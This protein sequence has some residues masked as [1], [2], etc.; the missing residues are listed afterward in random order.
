MPLPAGA[1]LV[2]YYLDESKGWESAVA[3][4]EQAVHEAR[5]QGK[6]LKALVVINPVSGGGG[7]WGLGSSG[8]TGW[9]AGCPPCTNP[10]ICSRGV[11]SA[12]AFPFAWCA[13]GVRPYCIGAA[14][15]V[16]HLRLPE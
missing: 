10:G 13:S 7:C 1:T 12:S 14:K 8:E 2:P 15:P 5:A 3:S 4:L 9:G 11:L 16:S 6:K